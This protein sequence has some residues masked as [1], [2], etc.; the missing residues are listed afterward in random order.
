M[1]ETHS[2]KPAI[3]APDDS[4]KWLGEECATLEEL[5][6]LASRPRRKR[7]SS[8]PSIRASATSGTKTPNSSGRPGAATDGCLPW[9]RSSLF[10]SVNSKSAFLGNGHSWRPGR[11][12]EFRQLRSMEEWRAVESYHSAADKHHDP[13]RERGSGDYLGAQGCVRTAGHQLHLAKCI[14]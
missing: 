3:L 2:R 12:A 8:G 14:R 5:R 4:A 9:V 11:S 1:A 10:R 7:C 6:A 13:S